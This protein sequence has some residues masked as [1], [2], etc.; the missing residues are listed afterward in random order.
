MA[1][2]ADDLPPDL[3]RGELTALAHDASYTNLDWERSN[4]R[5]S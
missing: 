1:Q 5:G 4:L 2:P 3:E